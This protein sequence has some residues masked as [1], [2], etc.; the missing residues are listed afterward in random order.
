MVDKIEVY[1]VNH[2]GKSERVDARKYAAMK[3][4]ILAVLPDRE[5]GLTVADA[6][7]AAKARLPEDTFPGGVTSGW[8]FKC[9][10]LDLE[11]RKILKRS[12]SSPLRLWRYDTV[13]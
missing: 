5:P 7:T 12:N 9:V 2:P 8:W 13:S 11:A 6:T 1:N 10:Q 3:A 4:A